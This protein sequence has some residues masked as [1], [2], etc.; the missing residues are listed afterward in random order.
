MPGKPKTPFGV[1]LPCTCRG[2]QGTSAQVPLGVEEQA[3]IE[4]HQGGVAKNFC[5]GDS[6]YIKGH[7]PV[8]FIGRKRPQKPPVSN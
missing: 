3:V 4:E 2:Y 7:Y 5:S 6:S 8:I 1:G